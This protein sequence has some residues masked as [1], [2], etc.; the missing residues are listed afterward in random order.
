MGMRKHIALFCFIGLFSVQMNGQNSFILNVYGGDEALPF[1]SVEIAV[2]GLQAVCDNNGQLVVDDIEFNRSY[3]L[4]IRYLGYQPMDT[5]LVVDKGDAEITF[6]LQEIPFE[7]SEMVVSGTRTN[8]RRLESAVAVHVIDGQTF[9]MTNSGTLAEGMCFQPGLRVE[10]DCQTCNYTQLRMNGLAG[11]YTQVL[12]DSR[13]I[14]SSIMSLYSLEQIPASQIERV[15]VVRGGGSILYGANAIAG[16]VNVITKLP[17]ESEWSFKQSF[18]RI[19][20]QSNDLA[21]QLN[22]TIVDEE[23]KKGI[24]F[25]ASDRNRLAYDHNGDGY[26]EL[27]ALRTTSFGSKFFWK[28]STIHIFQGNIWKIHSFRRGGNA[29]DLP[30]DQADQAEERDHNIIAGGLEYTFNPKGKSYWANAY[31]SFQDTDRRHYT[32][33]DQSDGWG[34]T[35]SNTLVAGFQLNKKWNSKFGNQVLTTGYEYQ[36]DN[37]FDEIKAY[38]FLID[39]QIDLGGL[40]L[41]GDFS[42]GPK[43]S[44]VSGL[45]YNTHTNLEKAI[46]TP[47][48]NLLFKPDDLNQIRISWAKGFKP[49]QAFETDMH[50]AFSGGGISRIAIAEDL[51]AETSRSYNLS[52]DFNKANIKTVYGFTLSGFY[53][54]LFDA[55]VLE[56]LGADSLGNQV[57]LRKNSGTSTV[58]GINI[59]SRW[60]YDQ[61]FQLEAGLTIQ[62]SRYDELISWSEDLPGNEA[63]L[64]TPDQYGFMTLALFPSSKLSATISSVYTGSMLVPH[65][66]GAPEQA[67]DELYVSDPFWEVNCK[68]DYLMQHNTSSTDL[69]LS[70]G[71]QNIFNAYQHNFDTGRYRDSN[72]VF[73]PSRPRSVVLSVVLSSSK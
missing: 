30:A 59:E 70:L 55:F 6:V 56:E 29:F 17:K 4:S 22:G 20:Q 12:I 33:V 62:D 72:F 25:Y 14:F 32:G 11:S 28:P 73:G 42:I 67:E 71:V 37:T 48:A 7:L 49:A 60:N 35:I 38:D 45:R 41:Q 54:E 46:V 64:R 47:R 2:L 58:R 68:L 19:N 52:W 44:L 50:I 43:W 15:E 69:K 16:T 51:I 66:G 34:N 53:T 21:F 39:Q 40:F 63:F 57:L 18:T 24:S 13:P 8:K 36:Y 23:Q 26:S 65:F 5:T 61:K 9:E 1:A 3:D 27:S 10:T 31:L